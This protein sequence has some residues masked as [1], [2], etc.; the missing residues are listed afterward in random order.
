MLIL[1]LLIDDI[2][3]NLSAFIILSELEK[4]YDEYGHW[5]EEVYVQIDGGSEFSNKAVLGM[6]SLIVCK[7]MCRVL[8]LTRLPTGHTHEDIDGIV[9]QMD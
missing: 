1:S 8:L 7:R 4:F 2:G 6:C 5:P 3:A 9:L